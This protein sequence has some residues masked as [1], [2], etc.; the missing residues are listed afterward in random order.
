MQKAGGY[1]YSAD[2][3]H[4]VQEMQKGMG[5][6]GNRPGPD[7][8]LTNIPSVL[9]SASTD[10]GDVSWVV[11]T[12]QFTAATFVPGT[13]PHTWQAA[14]CAGTSI[15]RK[16]MMVAARTLA[17]AGVDLFENPAQLQAARDAFEKRRA[18]RRW[19]T[20]IAPDAKPP[21]NY[22]TK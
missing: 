7:N 20:H 3:L 14:A 4:F 8:V 13:A 22:V 19:T 1:D 21:L 9:S 17:L 6:T 12:G 5:N 10:V 11:P 18:G 16:G 15:G 2:E